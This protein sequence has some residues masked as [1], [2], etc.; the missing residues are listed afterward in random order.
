MAMRTLAASPASLVTGFSGTPTWAT[1][2]TIAADGS[3]SIGV[4]G[5]LT[6]ASCFG[7]GGCTATRTSTL[8]VP[9]TVFPDHPF[10]HPDIED[11]DDDWYWFI[12]NKWYEVT[13]YA[14]APSHL[15]SGATHNCSTSGDCLT[16]TG[17]TTS[18]GNRALLVLMGRSLTNAA[19]PNASLAD[20]L[21][22]AENR[23]FDSAF[24]QDKF[25]KTFNDRFFTLS[26][27]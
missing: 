17:T 3:V 25:G 23:N 20:H 11:A 18:S 16:V 21:D 8:T 1:P 10:L 19:R 22:N 6:T 27:Y 2:N 5:S 13:Y 12:R 26:S 14:V 4:S 15:P 9:I 24:S 7:I